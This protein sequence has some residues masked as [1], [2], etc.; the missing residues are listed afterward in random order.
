MNLY[1]DYVRKALNSGKV[2][3]IKQTKDDILVLG[4]QWLETFD[5]LVHKYGIGKKFDACD[6]EHM[7]CM[8][9]SMHQYTL[10]SRNL[11]W[12]VKLDS[13]KYFPI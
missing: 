3:L 9:Y 8:I 1:N 13:E 10:P 5:C 7:L 11:R 2:S 4:L 12:S 6:A